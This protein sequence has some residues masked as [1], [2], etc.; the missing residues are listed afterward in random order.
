LTGAQGYAALTIVP[1][2][3]LIGAYATRDISGQPTRMGS[4]IAVRL[5]EI[6]Y[7][8]YLVHYLVIQ[9]F[10]HYTRGW[11]PTLPEAAAAV[12]ALLVVAFAF[13]S[14]L[15]FLVESPAERRLRPASRRPEAGPLTA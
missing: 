2:I 4:A 7:A 5:G 12:L 6:S 11:R 10:A 8:F 13:A 3:V 15:Y 14:A 1:F 9:L